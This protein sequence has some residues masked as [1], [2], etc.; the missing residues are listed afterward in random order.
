M[1]NRLLFSAFFLLA[2]SASQMPNHIPW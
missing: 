1:Q 2:M